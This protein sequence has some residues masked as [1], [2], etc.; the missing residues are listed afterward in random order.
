[1]AKRKRA[2]W[3][4]AA[5]A[6]A[7]G[8]CAT[9]AR[10]E[11]D[12]VAGSHGGGGTG[13]ETGTGGEAGG[14]GHA[15][16]GGEAGGG[17]GDV[18]GTGGSG[19]TGGGEE[20]T[21]GGRECV[22]QTCVEGKCTG[23]CSPEDVRCSGNR[24]QRCDARGAWEDAEPCP[25]AAPVCREGTCM[26]QPSCDGLAETCGPS[27]DESC[28]A[29]R[30]VIPGGTF[31]RDN[32]P[33]YPATVSGFVL[34]RF[35]V[36]VGR[37]RQ[38][39]KAYPESKP[40]P[41]AGAHPLIAG[42]GWNENWTYE[43][44]MDAEALKDAVICSSGYRTWTVEAG[45][46]EHLPMT[47][48]TWYEAFAFCAWDGGRLPTETEWNYAAAGGDE[49]REYPWSNPA[50]STTIDDSYAVYGCMG[51]GDA[52]DDC[53]VNDIQAVGSR[54]P[55]GDGRWG[56]ADLA[57]NIW[58]WVLDSYVDH[59]SEC[60]DCAKLTNPSLR[61]IRG[62]GWFYDASGL[63]SYRRYDGT[64]WYRSHVGVRCARTL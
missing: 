28:C 17:T 27:G 56:Q 46:R 31:D 6:L 16:A 14:G 5:W 18:A 7:A 37:F 36:T 51:N 8:G 54:S 55:K 48:L 61:A 59:P 26:M 35:E 29:R 22:G 24:P 3:L 9:L 53:G 63:L 4:W 62:G 50:S 10:P 15:A 64:P 21:P 42:S 43:L 57:G 11:N 41:G 1:M 30:E 33:A 45:D 20:C 49:Q 52:S 44:P 19:G 47:C 34:D 23:E 2:T 38:F 58:E 60:N 32:D 39:V 13:A 25:A 12:V 40:A